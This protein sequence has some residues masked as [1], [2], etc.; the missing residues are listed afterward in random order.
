[1]LT[2]QHHQ[3]VEVVVAGVAVVAHNVPATDVEYQNHAVNVLNQVA[4]ALSAKRF[5]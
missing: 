4:D 2:G 5:Y 1:M 3:V